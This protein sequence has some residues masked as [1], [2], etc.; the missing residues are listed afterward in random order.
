MCRGANVAILYW[1]GWGALGARWL[2][3]AGDSLFVSNKCALGGKPW[4]LVKPSD[5]HWSWLLL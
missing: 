5:V 3:L 2:M 4:S 1:R